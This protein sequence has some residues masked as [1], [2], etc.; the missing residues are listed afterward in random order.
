MKPRNSANSGLGKI[1]CSNSHL[2]EKD[3]IESYDFKCEGYEISNDE[4]T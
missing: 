1:N 3:D 2:L 4:E